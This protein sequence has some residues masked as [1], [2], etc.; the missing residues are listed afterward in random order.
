[1]ALG[2]EDM[3]L[4]FRNARSRNGWQAKPVGDEQLREFYGLI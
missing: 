2:P 4:I 3:D 1:M